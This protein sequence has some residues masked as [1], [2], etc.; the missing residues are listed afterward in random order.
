MHSN[1][2]CDKEDRP[3]ILTAD[4]VYAERD[5]NENS[6]TLSQDKRRGWVARNTKHDAFVRAFLSGFLLFWSSPC[7]LR[8][9]PTVSCAAASTAIRL[10][11]ILPDRTGLS[12]QR[13][14]LL[15]A[16]SS[17]FR[18]YLRDRGSLPRFFFLLDPSFASPSSTPGIFCLI[19]L[20]A[21]AAGRYI[22]PSTRHFFLLLFLFS[23]RSPHINIAVLS[24]RFIAERSLPRPRGPGSPRRRRRRA[25]SVPAFSYQARADRRT[26]I[27]S[28]R[29]SSTPS[30]SSLCPCLSPSSSC[31]S[32]N[33]NVRFRGFS[34]F[35]SRC[36]AR[37]ALNPRDRRRS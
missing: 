32:A 12:L 16:L 36:L 26:R 6:L 28:L 13:S 17:F 4:R 18:S 27:H 33:Y 14:F 10:S 2:V 19:I 3:R 22:S 20:S 37:S 24:E 1:L 25:G 9:L 23:A 11:P 35:V 30:R 5:S 31:P 7:T 29:S 34:A 21:R 15:L 8:P